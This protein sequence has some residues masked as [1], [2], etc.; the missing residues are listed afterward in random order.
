[1]LRHRLVSMSDVIP[2]GGVCTS[3][4]CLARVVATPGEWLAPACREE[5]VVSDPTG[6]DS[7]IRPPVLP[8]SI[9]FRE[10]FEF[11][12]EFLTDHVKGGAR[13]SACDLNCKVVGLHLC[14]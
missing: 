14:D 4:T 2:I 12:Q 13:I 3:T 9:G 7:L 8:S 10:S 11:R 1:M 5:R 6:M